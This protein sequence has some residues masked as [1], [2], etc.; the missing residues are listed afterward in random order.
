MEPKK[1]IAL[2]L[3]TIAGVLGLYFYF[4]DKSNASVD[5]KN[6]LTDA[7]IRRYEAMGASGVG[8]AFVVVAENIIS[9]ERTDLG[10]VTLWWNKALFAGSTR[11]N[12]VFA[13]K[14]MD[15]AKRRPKS[16]QSRKLLLDEARRRLQIAI[17]NS[18]LMVSNDDK[19]IEDR[20]ND[21]DLIDKDFEEVAALQK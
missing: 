18:F 3:L 9:T 11:Q 12:M 19:S 21:I 6:C 13:H 14:L 2:S 15:E 17:S 8:D 16:S 7:E 4:F 10:D 1:Y 20:R 5:C